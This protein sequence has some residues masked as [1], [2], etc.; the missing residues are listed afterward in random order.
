[1]QTNDNAVNLRPFTEDIQD[2]DICQRQ[3]G[4]I[5]K[6]TSKYK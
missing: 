4:K 3:W 1:M 2:I 5:K 6:P